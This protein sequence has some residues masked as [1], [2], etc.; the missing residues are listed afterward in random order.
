MEAGHLLTL[1]SIFF[2]S[3]GFIIDDVKYILANKWLLLVLN[4]PVTFVLLLGLYRLSF[5]T[6]KWNKLLVICYLL[7][8]TNVIASGI[9]RLSEKEL[10]YFSILS[11]IFVGFVIVITS[12]YVLGKLLTYMF[13]FIYIFYYLLMGLF[14]SNAYYLGTVLQLSIMLFGVAFGTLYFIQQHNRIQAIA[15]QSQQETQK[16]KTL[17]KE[18]QTDIQQTIRTLENKVGKKDFDLAQEITR[19]KKWSNNDLSKT[20]FEY[21]QNVDSKENQFFNALL[22]I[23]PELTSN[24]L[25]LC[26]MLLNNMSTKEIAENTICTPDSVKVFR[27]RLR[28]KL[29][30]DRS[31]NLISYLKE[32]EQTSRHNKTPN[33]S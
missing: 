8:T 15:R 10:P 6:K 28:K 12:A 23:H 18:E 4:L 33:A 29:N 25:K 11:N 9:Y 26:S 13:C 3:I 14:I 2:F 7:I 27:S 24:E 17:I 1:L 19:I 20:L 31:I 16:L 5:S 22:E 30:L 32:I 21:T